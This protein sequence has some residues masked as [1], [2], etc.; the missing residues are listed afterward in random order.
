MNSSVFPSELKIAKVLPLFKGEDHNILSNFR[1]ISILPVF[2]KIFEKLIQTRLC[3]FFDKEKVLNEGQFG[4]RRGRSTVQA[5][6]TSISNIIKSLNA[7]HK[8]IGIFIDFSK[9]FDTIKH[10]ILMGKL[11]HYGIRGKAY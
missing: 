9:A 5:L 6:Y 3:S 10:S 2:S 8:T 1:P 4:F 11:S 7:K